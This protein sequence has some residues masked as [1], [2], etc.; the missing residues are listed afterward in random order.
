MKM[1][2]SIKEIAP[3]LLQAQMA[4]KCALKDATNP[5][6]RSS[7]A[8]LASVID[9]VKDGLNKA[10]IAFMQPVSAT[11]AGVAVE[12]L[13]LHKSGEWVSETLPIPVDKQNAQ[14]V[15]SA[16]TYGRR[17]GLQSLCGVPAT[18]DDGNAA[19]AAPPPEKSVTPTSGVLE[20]L[21]AKRQKI[22]MDTAVMVKDALNEDRP[23]DAYGLCET[24]NFDGDEKR[25]LWSLL[26]SKARS[27]LKRLQDSERGTPPPKLRH[28]VI[29]A[30]PGSQP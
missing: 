27:T 6:F 3:A 7:Y 26:D 10:G 15:G 22:V 29:A 1:S 25:A 17:Y 2:E 13:L 8:D 21:S 11:D 18:D 5:H 16:I 4:I 19:A 14:G 9:A 23:M 12:T 20:G 24:S 30:D 28:E